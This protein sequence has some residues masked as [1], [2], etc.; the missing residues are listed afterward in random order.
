M[1]VDI[2]LSRLQRNKSYQ[3]LSDTPSDLDTMP[4]TTT[5]R[6]RPSP[7]VSS[8]RNRTGRKGGRYQDEPDDEEALLQG[9]DE[10]G[11]QGAEDAGIDLDATAGDGLP[12]QKSGSRVSIFEMYYVPFF[13]LNAFC[14]HSRRARGELPTRPRMTSHGLYRSALQV[15]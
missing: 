1:P 12:I 7:G 15:R 6:N 13:S 10:S 3:P 8:P 5:R 2:P 11:G 9:R 4:S 14:L